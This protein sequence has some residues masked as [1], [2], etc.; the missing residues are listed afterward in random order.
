MKNLS[1]YITKF[2]RARV[3]VIG[4][5]ILDEYVRGSVDR[6]S[7]EAPVPIVWAKERKFVPGGAANVAN[8]LRSLGAQVSL[9]GVVGRDHY[10]DIMLKELRA[11]GIDT[12]A[13]IAEKGR[14][15]TLKSRIF[16]AHQ[17]VVRVDWENVEPILKNTEHKLEEYISA[18]LKKFDAVIIEDYGKGVFTNALL[19]GIISLS[20]RLGT[21]ITVDP[22]E[23]NFESY[24]GVTA[25][26]PNRKEAQN[27]IRYLKMKDTSNAF[28]VY[29]DALA[30]DAD[31]RRAGYAILHH[32]QLD[33]LLITLGENGMWLFEKDRD[34]HIPTVAQE[35]F[36]V[37]GA[38]DTTI[39]TFTLA[40][41]SGMSKYEAAVVANIAAGI[42]VGKL[43]TA[44]VTRAELIERMRI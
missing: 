44:T 11:R 5:L 7:P 14:Q 38:G 36:D 23:D 43:G 26:T 39:A 20:R 27:A 16:A 37:S 40:L 28:K 32:L 9:S 41:C 21:I 30:T 2:S 15:T 34:E 1:S 3:L 29:H 22:K 13:I 25:I 8:N 12:T 19:S 31:I 24:G 17:Q 10:R 42:V 6:I 35:V 33:S 4:D 18:T